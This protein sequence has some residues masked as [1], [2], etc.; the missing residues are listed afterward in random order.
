MLWQSDTEVLLRPQLQETVI[1]TIRLKFKSDAPLDGI[2]GTLRS[3]LNDQLSF[4]LDASGEIELP[5][6]A[7]TP[8][9][10]LLSIDSR[11]TDDYYIPSQSLRLEGTD[12]TMTVKAQKIEKQTVKLKFTDPSGY[13]VEGATVLISTAFTR[14]GYTLGADG[15]L[16][17]EVLVESRNAEAKSIS[18]QIFGKNGNIQWKDSLYLSLADVLNG[19]YEIRINSL[20]SIRMEGAGRNQYERYLFYTQDGTK[21]S[22]CLQS[23]NS[24]V[25]SH[26]IASGGELIA[27]PRPIDTR[28]MLPDAAQERYDLLKSLT[29]IQS[30]VLNKETA[31]TVFRIDDSK[32]EYYTV[33]SPTDLVG[34]RIPAFEYFV[35]NGDT[36]ILASLGL[37]W[38]SVRIPK[39][40]NG[41]RVI[42]RPHS[43]KDISESLKH[44]GTYC[45]EWILDDLSPHERSFQLGFQ[46]IY[47]FRLED[48][49][50][51]PHDGALAYIFNNSKRLTIE[52]SLRVNI[53]D[54]LSPPETL[55]AAWVG[56]VEKYTA[57]VYS[58]WADACNSG[59]AARF[60]FNDITTA[61][62]ETIVLTADYELLY[63]IPRYTGEHDTNIKSVKQQ[64]DG[65][66]LV[67]LTQNGANGYQSLIALP[68]GAFNVM[69]DG[70][71]Q[72]SRELEL[73]SGI[74]SHD[75]S[76]CISEAD[77][78]SDNSIRCY[79]ITPQGSRSL[80]FVREID[81]DI[82]AYSVPMKVSTNEVMFHEAL[83]NGTSLLG[84]G[85]TQPPKIRV[86]WWKKVV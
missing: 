9:D 49:D 27:V 44:L 2:T 19:E 69:L 18:V 74:I 85:I 47:E 62:P 70:T 11:L 15:I 35:L 77:L 5:L 6:K 40:T 75:V 7:A 71:E 43:T 13:S 54:P 29:A 42:I 37:S 1:E 57:S 20:I 51:N 53:S 12:Y 25:P 66:Y 34:N 80:Q 41:Q 78:K 81:H 76:F 59:T 39:L 10:Y 24:A 14:K 67:R 84:P 8:G 72:S 23:D 73:Q 30:F 63:R 16:S 28:L 68:A 46:S 64:K 52:S 58:Y 61:Y 17:A 82:F 56:Y 86:N 48:K 3:N 45:A 36:P 60:D 31:E 22:I 55:F 65:S 33:N 21:K 38:T 79:I 4:R 50:G 26:I 83:R 32:T